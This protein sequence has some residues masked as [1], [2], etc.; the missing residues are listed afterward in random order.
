MR[1]ITKKIF[2]HISQT[3]DHDGTYVSIDCGYCNRKTFQRTT[4]DYKR[5]DYLLMKNKIIETDW[6]NVID[7]E[8]DINSACSTVFVL[9]NICRSLSRLRDSRRKSESNQT[10]SSLRIVTSLD[11]HFMI[12]SIILIW[13]MMPLRNPMF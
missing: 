4:W 2:V 13:H 11:L 1:K 7:A 8:I 6:E 9:K 12:H 10:L 3:D 5:G